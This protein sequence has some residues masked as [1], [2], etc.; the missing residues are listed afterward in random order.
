MQLPWAGGSGEPLLAGPKF[1]EVALR[2]QKK[3]N[4]K[5]Q[6][7][8]Q[9]NGTLLN[10]EWINFFKE[11]DFGV[12]I[13]LD[14]KAESHDYSRIHNN[15]KKTFDIVKEKIELCKNY[16]LRV[17]IIQTIINNNIKNLE[18]DWQYIYEKLRQKSWAINIYHEE[19]SFSKK[20]KFGV[21][22]NQLSNIYEKLLNFWLEKD[23][24]EP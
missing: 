3:Y 14:G 15:N 12:G 9:T 1:Y 23:P 2:L 8:I 18:D 6:N 20:F 24:L 10:K 7:Y 11:H 21:T 5:T 17:G 4:A 22:N 16:E 19:S 13:S